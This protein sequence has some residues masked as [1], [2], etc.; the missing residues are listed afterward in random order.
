M[1]LTTLPAIALVLLGACGP[2]ARHELD[3]Y[4]A[5]YNTFVRHMQG[6]SIAAL[7]AAQGELVTGGGVIRGPDSIRTFLAGFTNVTVDS[8]AMWADSVNLSDSG[9]VQW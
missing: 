7:Y 8:S 9:A 3:G 1:R 4:L 5:R 2:D 6:D